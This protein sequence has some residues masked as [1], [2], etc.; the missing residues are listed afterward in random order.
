MLNYLAIRT[1]AMSNDNVNFYA[2]KNTSPGFFETIK[3]FFQEVYSSRYVIWYLFK[4]DFIAQF[5]QKILGYFWIVIAPFMAVLPFIFLTKVGI[6]RPGDT[7]M[8]YPVFIVI[9]LG[10]W[11][12][13]TS[14]FSTVSSCL[15]QNEDLIKRTN[16]PKITFA[17]TAMAAIVYN[18]LVHYLVV[19]IFLILMGETPSVWSILY[20]FALLP[21]LLFGMG[22]GLLFAV[23]GTIARDLSNIILSLL[24]LLLF[25]S[26]VVYMPNF[27]HWFLKLIVA[28]NPFTYLVDFPRN[29]LVLGT[30]K[31]AAGFVFAA[32][33]ALFLMLIGVYSFYLIKD[34][35]AEQL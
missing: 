13:L 15:Q 9:G 35:V 3:I 23:I 16:I 10:V 19:L 14:S 24:N 1:H 17:L 25:L 12:L 32:L 22:L 27:S 30:F 21:V 5:R 7:N 8:S 11:G 18:L 28:W 34:R 29:I 26:P 4:R 33:F 6:F 31:E 2:S 20:P